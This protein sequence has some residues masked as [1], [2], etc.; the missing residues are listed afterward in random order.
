MKNSLDSVMLLGLCSSMRLLSLSC[1]ISPIECSRLRKWLTRRLASAGLLCVSV[2]CDSGMLVCEVSVTWCSMCS[3]LV[4]LSFGL[5]LG[6]VRLK[7]KVL[8][9]DVTDV[10]SSMT[11]YSRHTYNRKTGII[12][13]VLKIRLQSACVRHLVKLCP[14]SLNSIAVIAVLMVVRCRC[15]T[16][17]GT[18]AQ[19]SYRV[20]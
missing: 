16:A 14:V 5:M 18:I 1:L 2:G 19:V 6:C 3:R 15:M 7:W 13:S 17:V 9:V 4:N 10:L 12:V 8:I 11:S 20:I